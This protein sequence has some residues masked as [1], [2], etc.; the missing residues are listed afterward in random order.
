MKSSAAI[1][2]D[3]SI[4]E[5]FAFVANVE[6]ME[7]WVD[8]V[9]DAR[10]ASDGEVAVGSTIESDYTYRGKTFEMDME[11]TAF[12]EPTRFGTRATEGPFPFDGLVEL[13]EIPGGTRVTNTIDAGS[14]S[15][16]TTVIFT[17]G[18]PIVR[19]MMRKQLA[20]ELEELRDALDEDAAVEAPPA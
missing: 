15:W 20:T 10:L 1:D 12:E 7:R 13:E 16:M 9:G 8:G 18:G 19:R 2:V 5:V 17:L 4:E 11:V 3:R 6:N 14:D